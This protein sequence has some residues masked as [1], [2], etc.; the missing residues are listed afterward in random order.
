LNSDF[1][2][3]L[4]SPFLTRHWFTLK[5]ALYIFFKSRLLGVFLM[6]LFLI[7]ASALALAACGGAADP[8]PAETPPASASPAGAE[9]PAAAKAS[10][11]A[12]E[13]RELGSTGTYTIDPGHTSVI[14]KVKHLG[15]SNYTARFTDVDATLEFNPSDTALTSLSVTID[16]K[17]VAANY[18]GDYKGTHADSGFETWDEDLAMNEKWFNANQH[19]VITF[20]ATSITKGG[21]NTGQVTELSRCAAP[22]GL[23]F[24]PPENWIVPISA[25]TTPSRL[26]ALRLIS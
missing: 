9:T 21:P 15:M 22:N 16:P 14:W 7:G 13:A 18:V 4:V 24:Q 10:A 25:W 2:I 6:R 17:S 23:V 26:S 19:D 5:T 12:E 20:T 1:T 3:L 8:K 11:P